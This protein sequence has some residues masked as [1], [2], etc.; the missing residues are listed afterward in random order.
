[1]SARG[2]RS[3]PLRLA[4]G[5]RQ[6]IEEATLEARFEEGRVAVVLADPMADVDDPRM[7]FLALVNQILRFSP[8]VLLGTDDR[9]LLAAARALAV[10]I[11]GPNAELPAIGSGEARGADVV[12]DV[13]DR[14]TGDPSW[15]T[16]NSSG[17]VAR[18][19][20][21]GDEGRLP[22]SAGSSNALGALAAACLGAGEAFLVLSGVHRATRAWE[23][24]LLEGGTGVP[25][26]FGPGP[27]LPA[28]PIELDGLLVGCGG[29]ANGWADAIRRLPVSGR[30]ITVDRQA[31]RIENLGPYVLARLM[32][33]GRPKAELLKEALERRLDVVSHAEE[34]ELFSLRLS[35][36]LAL[37]PLVVGGLDNVETRHSIQ[38]LWPTALVDMAAGGTTAQV[39]GHMAG[40][41]GQ[42]LLGALTLPLEAERYEDRVSELT[43]LRPERI[44]EGATT[45]VTAEDVAAAPPG[46]REKLD[47]ARRR[48]QLLCGRITERNLTGEE[49]TEDF[50]PAAPFVSAL[51]GTIGAA[52]TMKLL[53]GLN[54]ISGLHSQYDFRGGKGRALQMR[55]S[56]SCECRSSLRKESA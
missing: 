27:D 41:G 34:F 53:L 16:V 23:H 18:L 15:I 33:L 22:W 26:A 52:E 39:L 13:G 2:A 43:G 19:L 35:F 50:A 40:G 45:P 10:D 17:W 6:G 38:R 5:L 51:A 25:G 24:S 3:R 46:M 29:V 1:V 8:H 11:H 31:L 4:A 54:S 55:C 30:L 20:S 37:P 48:G 49:A 14:S 47:A 44:L 32:D 21:G 12:V 28:T 7:T 9:E 56:T 42:C 36:G